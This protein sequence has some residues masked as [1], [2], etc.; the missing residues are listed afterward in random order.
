VFVHRLVDRGKTEG[1][2]HLNLSLN[3]TQ[4]C[5]QVSLT[6]QTFGLAANWQLTSFGHNLQVC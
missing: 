6:T 5:C 3:K 1:L 2:Q 4:N